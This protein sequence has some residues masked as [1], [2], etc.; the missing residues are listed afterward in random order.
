MWNKC[1]LWSPRRSCRRLIVTDLTWRVFDALFSQL[2]APPLHSKTTDWLEK[3]E[4]DR[5][6][7]REWEKEGR[8]A[9]KF[10][11]TWRIFP[12]SLPPQFLSDV[13]LCALLVPFGWY[14]SMENIWYFT[15]FE[16]RDWI[17]YVF[18]LI[19][20]QFAQN[21]GVFFPEIDYFYISSCRVRIGHIKYCPLKK[22][23]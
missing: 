1:L 18:E 17:F 7:E 10:A 22:Y 6:R 2:S 5:K 15:Y 14:F 23:C 20:H 12:L 19:F 16:W 13:I 4:D 9:I 8:R 3:K 21:S 11:H